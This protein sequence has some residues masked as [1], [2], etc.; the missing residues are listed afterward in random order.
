MLY[1]KRLLNWRFISI[2]QKPQHLMYVL[3]VMISISDRNLIV[4]TLFEVFKNALRKT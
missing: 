1:E 2:V 4:G 3:I